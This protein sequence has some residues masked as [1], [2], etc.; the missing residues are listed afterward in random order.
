MLQSNQIKGNS[1]FIPYK[2]TEPSMY[3]GISK[4]N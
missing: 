3:N 4:L 2:L 1:N